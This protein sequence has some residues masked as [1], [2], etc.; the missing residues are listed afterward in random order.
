MN[1]L[2]I[3]GIIFLIGG[4]ANLSS[5]IGTFIFGVILGA[6]LLY[7]GIRKRKKKPVKVSN[8][9]LQTET[10]NVVGVTYYLDNIH[11]LACGN[12]DWKCTAAQIISKGKTDERIFRYNF[13]HKPVKLIPEPDNKHD[14]NAVAV[15]IAGELVGYISREENQHVLDI[16]RNHEIKYISGFVGGGEYK[17][18]RENKEIHRFED[19]ISI[20]IK[21]GHVK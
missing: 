20:R 15:H 9:E 4:I 16:L 6:G 19:D 17:I 21:I 1:W 2:I 5:S 3:A 13:I 18:I 14:K 8:R 7:L 11:K 10:F 12:P